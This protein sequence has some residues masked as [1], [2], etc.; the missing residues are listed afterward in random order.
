M[1]RD[2]KA[3]RHADVIQDH[4]SMIGQSDTLVAIDH[5]VGWVFG[6]R[7]F[8]AVA[9]AKARTE[10][11]RRVA[12][13]GTVERM[14]GRLIEMV[15]QFWKYYIQRSKHLLLMISGSISRGDTPCVRCLVTGRA[16][17]AGV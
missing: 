14:S 4:A 13:S 9:N 6:W 1:A 7:S 8:K 5:L 12:H 3:V 10:V 2:F 17:Q 16:R 11:A 15:G